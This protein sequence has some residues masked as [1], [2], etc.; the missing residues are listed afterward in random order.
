MRRNEL[1][2]EVEK[3]LGTQEYPE[4]IYGAI[5]HLKN[6]SGCGKYDEITVEEVC[7]E[8]LIRAR[9]VEGLETKIEKL[10]NQGRKLGENEEVKNIEGFVTNTSYY[11]HNHSCMN[12]PNLN[13]N[14]R[15]LP[16]TGRYTIQS[17]NGFSV[18]EMYK[19]FTCGKIWES[20]AG[21]QAR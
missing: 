19:C 4:V 20:E 21:Y 14:A 17:E 5:D 13:P 15:P 2:Y 9:E 8:I 1:G 18:V 3:T 10:E 11:C 12:A 16:L 6:T 7:E